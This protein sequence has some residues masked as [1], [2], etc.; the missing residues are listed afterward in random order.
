MRGVSKSSEEYH[1]LTLFLVANEGP[2]HQR[3]ESLRP[4]ARDT[5]EDSRSLNVLE[6]A[7]KGYLQDGYSGGIRWLQGDRETGSIGY[8]V[9]GGAFHLRYTITKVDYAYAVALARTPAPLGGERVWFVCPLVV[10]GKSCGRRV[11]KLYLP[12]GGR[13]FGC[14]Y[15]HGLSYEKRQ[16]RTPAWA[17]AWERLR[18]LEEQLKN[19]RRGSRRTLQAYQ[20]TERILDALK[21]MDILKGLRWPSLADP[22]P[23]R[24]P[25]RPSK[26][27]LRELARAERAAATGVVV[28]WPR[29]RP[30]VKR[31]YMRRKPLLLSE[32][33]SDMEAY[34]VKC[35]DRREL[36]DPKPITLANG[37]PGVQ[38]T[39]PV[40]GTKATRI[41]KAA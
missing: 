14:R 30:K 6:F 36:R 33:R 9:A 24:G 29:G 41:V 27:E 37:R 1:T 26:R 4:M 21:G 32:R 18:K 8:F 16:K 2:I 22:R 12:P 39:C 34:C 31:A 40:C 10:N 35:R 38:G 23:R 15:C 28:R 19:P 17:R 3:L 20:E 5:V 7:R 13:Y 11:V 25:G